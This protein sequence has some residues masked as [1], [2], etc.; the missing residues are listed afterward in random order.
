MESNIESLAVAPDETHSFDFKAVFHDRYPRVVRLISRIVNDPGRSEDI[1]VEVFLKLWR[2]SNAQGANVNGWLYRTAVRMSL[3]GLRRQTRREKYEKV[4]G[5]LR[6]TR[7]PEQLHSEAQRQKQVRTVL[8]VMKPRL[9]ELLLLRSDGVSYQELA[10]ILELNPV[11]VGTLLSRA[12]KMFRRE[13]IKR[14]G[15]E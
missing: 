1:A 8:S 14:Y 3:D 9:A 15:P 2:T 12:Q 5:F 11:S 13:Y 4:L 6:T 7:T 10:Q